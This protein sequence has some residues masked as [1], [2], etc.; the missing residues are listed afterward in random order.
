MPEKK[1]G[2]K[3]LS[4][5]KKSQGKKKPP[6][7]LSIPKGKKAALISVY[8]KTGIVEFAQKLTKLGYFILS[9]GGTAKKLSEAG[10]PVTDVAELVGGEAI[11]GHRV[12]TLSRELHAGLLAKFALAD[13]KEMKK[14]GLPYIHLV[15][16]DFYPLTQEIAKQS[17]TIDSVVEMTDIGGPT[18]VRSA[19]KGGRIVICDPA[20]R[21]EVL[22]KLK[23]NKKLSSEE[24]E[25]LRAK[26]EYIVS[27]YCLD[28]AK[29]HSKGKITGLIG[30]F[31]SK[32]KY[33]ENAWQ[34]DDNTGLYSTN[35]NDPL[36]L[37]N[38]QLLTG[39]DPSFINYTDID[40]LLQTITHI[41]AGFDVNFGRVPLIACAVKHG[42][43]CGAAVG[44]DPNEVIKKMVLG[45][46]LAVFGGIVMTN[47]PL[48]AEMVETLL[49][50]NQPPD[51]RLLLDG[52]IAPHVTDEA[53]ELLRRKGDKCRI[54]TN[55]YLL[56]LNQHSLDTTER[57]RPV[58]GG[59]LRQPNYAYVLNLN[60]E[61]LTVTKPDNCDDLTEF[62]KEDIILA[63]AVGCT[64][65]SNTTCLTR[66]NQLLGDGVGQQSRVASCQVAVFRTKEAG[67]QTGAAMAYTDSFC[68]QPDAPEVLADA[69]VSILFASSGSVNDQI[70][71]ETCKKSGL[72]LVQL[73]DA[74][75]RGF[76][77]H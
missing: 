40:R 30:D 32:C 21:D 75:C 19:A 56:N 67:H 25:S 63:W 8:D 29:F 44:Y 36:A 68:P 69:G 27:K 76:F 71:Q 4:A 7:K 37:E 18:M 10:V 31:F 13:Q 54:L 14:L 12:V 35:S 48:T 38:F 58:R 16:C 59:F 46:H 51:K 41:A 55:K 6:S 65:N 64:S 33:G 2:K 57:I 50:I 15:C 22:Q 73:P 77:G 47:F 1:K 11:L 42:N 39:M 72:I 23:Q 53:I 61:R 66:A 17:A 62:D 28:S 24:I 5:T 52:V 74:V 3:K 60:D 9:S 26:A 70:V 20:D 43:P 49:T 45:D 34:N